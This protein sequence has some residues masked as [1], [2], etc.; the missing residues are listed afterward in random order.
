MVVSGAVNVVP[1]VDAVVKIDVENEQI[2]VEINGEVV[3]DSED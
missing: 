1:G 3:Y 2:V